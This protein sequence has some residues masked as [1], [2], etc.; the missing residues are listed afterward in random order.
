MISLKQTDGFT[1]SWK[2][3][4][5]QQ[6]QQPQQPPLPPAKTGSSLHQSQYGNTPTASSLS[7]PSGAAVYSDMR[8]PFAR[9]G[10][11]PVQQG[12]TSYSG[13]SVK[14]I[15]GQQNSV[16]KQ[17][18]TD[19]HTQIHTHTDTQTHIYTHTHTHT[20]THAHTTTTTTINQLPR[21]V[22]PPSTQRTERKVRGSGAKQNR[23][24][25]KMN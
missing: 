1:G 23:K 20:H 6:Q 3:G 24:Y 9:P 11:R 8:S 5:L 7:G 18:Q 25:S 10:S 4:M 12:R 21:G 15:S 2:A 13:S 14:A 17:I 19:R 16:S 22:T